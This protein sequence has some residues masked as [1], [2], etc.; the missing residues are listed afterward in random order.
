M[1][2]GMY[3]ERERLIQVGKTERDG[4]DRQEVRVI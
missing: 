4:K 3:G 1:Y 2:N